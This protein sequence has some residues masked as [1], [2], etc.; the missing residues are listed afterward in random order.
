MEFG[1]IRECRDEEG[2]EGWVQGYEVCGPCQAEVA[3]DTSVSNPG[4]GCSKAKPY[5]AWGA[6]E[7]EHLRMMEDADEQEE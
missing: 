6:I 3:S 4:G 2:L 7:E 1:E 5:V